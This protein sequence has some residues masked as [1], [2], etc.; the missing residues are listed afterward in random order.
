MAE[1]ADTVVLPRSGRSYFK[2]RGGGADFIERWKEGP[3]MCASRTPY[4]TISFLFIRRI[5]FHGYYNNTRLDHLAY[6]YYC[7]PMSHC[8]RQKRTS[9]HRM[10]YDQCTLKPP[11]LHSITLLM[12]LK[13]FS[14]NHKC[15]LPIYSLSPTDVPILFNPSYVE[16]WVSYQLQKRMFF[17]QGSI[18]FF[19]F[20]FGC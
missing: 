11:F 16:N 8:V 17:W 18:F 13:Q 10:N 2:P 1:V 20:S 7:P 3:I 14:C 12:L 19:F 9:A 15:L 6:Y 5:D 4:M